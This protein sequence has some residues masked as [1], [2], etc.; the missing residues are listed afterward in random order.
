MGG[1]SNVTTYNPRASTAR[2]FHES[3]FCPGRGDLVTGAGGTCGGR[4]RPRSPPRRGR[5]HG[6]A[7]V[8]GAAD[9]WYR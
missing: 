1:A 7:Q 9:V 8:F 5:G 3:N 4:G 6:G 2:D